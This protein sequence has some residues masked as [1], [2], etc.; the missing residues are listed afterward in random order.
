MATSHK[1]D[2]VNNQLGLPSSIHELF[3]R[4]GGS[5]CHPP[6]L[7]ICL[8]ETNP[9]APLA[10]E[11]GMDGEWDQPALVQAAERATPP[12]V[13]PA[14]VPAEPGHDQWVCGTGTS[15]HVRHRVFL[16]VWFLRPDTLCSLRSVRRIARSRVCLVFAPVLTVEHCACS[17]TDV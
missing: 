5:S 16:D 15:E 14:T 1:L 6:E 11:Y 4:G 3:K 8:A 17:G 12:E 2:D 9:M 10:N 7:A 13:D